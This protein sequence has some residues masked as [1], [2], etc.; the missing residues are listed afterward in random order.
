ML[1]PLSYLLQ[2]VLFVRSMNQLFLL[3]QKMMRA[4]K[5]QAEQQS[6]AQESVPSEPEEIRERTRFTEEG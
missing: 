5:Q 3:I 4:K 6:Q 1:L 2:A